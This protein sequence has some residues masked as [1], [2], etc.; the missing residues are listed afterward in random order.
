MTDAFYPGKKTDWSKE[1]I[2]Q[3]VQEELDESIHEILSQSVIE[4]C[5]LHDR[6][7]DEILCYGAKNATPEKDKKGCE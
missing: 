1:D 7:S 2:K 5:F 4:V 3:I 6:I